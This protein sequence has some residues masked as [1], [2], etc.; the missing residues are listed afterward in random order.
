MSKQISQAMAREWRKRALAAEGVLNQQ[1]SGWRAE[2]PSAT[3]LGRVR[4][5]PTSAAI[6]STARKLGH[7][8]VAVNDGDDLVMFGLPAAQGK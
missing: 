4:G 5:V 1:R 6:V 8:V 2:W 7:A 3:V